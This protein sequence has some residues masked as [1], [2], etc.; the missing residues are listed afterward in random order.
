MTQR[1]NARLAGVMFLLYIATGLT[2][3]VVFRQATGGAEGTAATLASLAQHPTAV[4]LTVV[5]TLLMFVYAVGLGVTLW[6]LTRDVDQDLAMVA[7]CC[8]VSEGVVGA[9]SSVRTLGLVS[10]A[11][12][13][14]GA[15]GP[16]AAAAN[17]LGGLLLEQGG[18]IPAFCFAVGSTLFCWLFL[19]GRSIPVLLA[20]LG[21]GASV[22]LLGAL[23]SQILGFIGRP[24]T[25]FMWIPMAVFEVVL[26]LWLI[27]KGVA[28]PQGQ[29]A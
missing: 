14:A 19:R 27:I 12:A 29:R 16:D 5:L 24:V 17:A 13:A 11:T 18:L 6:A 26:A 9:A 4:R 23:P 28:T 2:S 3:M 10:V 22:L 1:T 25:D 20:W 21:V 15:A 7:L 8:R